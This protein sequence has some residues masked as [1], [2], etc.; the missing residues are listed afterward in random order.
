MKNGTKHH[1]QFQ[2]LPQD[3]FNAFRR[4]LKIDHVTVEDKEVPKESVSITDVNLMISDVK[5]YASISNLKV[6]K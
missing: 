1:I 5:P 3:D 2:Q 6:T 4:V